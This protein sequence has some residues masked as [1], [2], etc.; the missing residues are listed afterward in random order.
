MEFLHHLFISL[1]EP[2]FVRLYSQG[3]R[4]TLS[5]FLSTCEKM[6]HFLGWATSHNR[7]HTN[8]LLFPFGVGD[9]TEPRA[10]RTPPLNTSN[11]FVRV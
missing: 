10:L 5:L 9:G 7:P 1:C 11:P 8:S 3:A 4:S 2:Q 6:T